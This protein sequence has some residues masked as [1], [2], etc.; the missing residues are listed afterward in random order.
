MGTVGLPLELGPQLG[1]SAQILFKLSSSPN[2]GAGAGEGKAPEI[3]H[4][5]WEP[6]VSFSTDRQ[7]QMNWD[8]CIHE[9]VQSTS[10]SQLKLPQSRKNQV[11]NKHCSYYSNNT[12]VPE[13]P[14]QV[15]SQDGSVSCNM[16]NKSTAP[17]RNTTPIAEDTD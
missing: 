1:S 17:S 7:Q 2:G 12:D 9:T 13:R 8:H 3:S 5:S 6:T 16:K 11:N 15:Q 14:D 4:L 10:R